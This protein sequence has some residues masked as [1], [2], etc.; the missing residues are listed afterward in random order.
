MHSNQAVS[1]ALQIRFAT[2]ERRKEDDYESEDIAH[3]A[4]HLALDIGIITNDPLL[5]AQAQEVL[6]TINRWRELQDE[7]DA[8][9]MADSHAAWDASQ[10]KHR[11]A[12]VMVKEL[13][14]KEFHDPRWSALIEIYQEAFPTFLVRGSVYARIDPKQGAS[15]LRH[16]LAELVKDKRLDRAPTPGEVHALLPSAKALLEERTIS[17]LE[18]ALPGFDFRGHPILSSK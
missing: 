4:A 12:Y 15:R 2:F 5:I 11:Q 14:G 7:Q 8:Q 18:R 6:T 13:V 1:Q 16:E 17:Y 3:G 9:Y 10:E